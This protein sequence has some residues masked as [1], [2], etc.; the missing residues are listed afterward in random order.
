M[1]VTEIGIL[2][3]VGPDGIGDGALEVAAAEAVRLGVGVE[4][5][6]V[7]HSHVVSVPTRDEHER[8][9]DRAHAAV[10]HEVLAD[11]ANRMGVLIDGQV[12]VT[13][14]IVTG[15]VGRTIVERSSATR[16]IVLE[17]RE[18]GPVGRLVTR[19][20]ST[21]V[22]AHAHVP[23]LV[24]PRAWT[25][26]VGADLPVTV[27]IDEPLDVKHEAPAALELA[28]ATG[29]PLVVLHAAWIAE[30]YQGVAFVGYPMKQWL[31]DAHR[32]LDTALSGMTSDGDA[33]TC[34]VHWARP[35]DALVRATQRSSLLVLSRRPASRPLAPHLG[36]VTRAVLHHAE[37]PVLVLDR[38]H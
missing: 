7:A 10:G 22:A 11:A 38:E 21:S 20:V 37:C 8:A 18:I 32:E 6:H 27:G 25:S 13:T 16:L 23:V 12:P 30:P 36:P 2:V 3:A 9:L 29:R 19:S 26:A 17:A 5:V 35:V 28:R 15:P 34:D 1:N 4:L 14:E 24:V 33:V 31:D